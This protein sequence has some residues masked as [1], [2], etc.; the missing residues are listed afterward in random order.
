[1]RGDFLVEGS[2]A[3]KPVDDEKNERGGRDGEI[4]LGLGCSGE[5]SRGVDALVANAAGVEEGVGPVG[6][7]GRDD[8]AG[9]AR[10]VVDD[11]DA[12]PRQ[13]IEEAALADVGSADDGNGTVNE[14]S[15]DERR[16][17]VRRNT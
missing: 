4:H 7:L 17:G 11:G 14:K 3:L 9:D 8:I 10:L 13:P 16:E 5:G 2:H 12:F 15:Q 6:D 1:M